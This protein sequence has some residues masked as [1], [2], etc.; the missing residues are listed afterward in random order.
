MV[1][2]DVAERVDRLSPVAW[3]G[4]AWRHLAPGRNPI[5]GEG[6]RVPGGRWNPP[7]SFPALY[8][9][10]DVDTVAAEFYRLAARQAVPPEGLLPREL[11][12]FEVTLAA[13]LDLREPWA[14]EQVGLD[15]RELSGDDL[16]ACQGVGAAARHL[17]RE[18]VLSPSAAG[19][20]TVLVV[21][22]DRLGAESDVRPLDHL[23]WR[24][25]PVSS[26]R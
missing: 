25:P 18:G 3:S 5:S 10:L 26:R 24:S 15:G 21:F 11:H 16:R 22:S 19:S 13:V 20:G 14:R 2:P 6:A 17:G 8:L 12:R 9:A 7:D 23:I 4:V 1:D